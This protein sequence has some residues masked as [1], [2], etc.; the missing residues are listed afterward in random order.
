MSCSGGPT[1]PSRT[2]GREH[3]PSSGSTTRAP[4]VL[5]PA[6]IY[7]SISGFGTAE[8]A[9]L[10][11]YD[12]VVQAVSGLM[13]LTGSPDGPAFR[14]GI[15]VFDVMTG[16]HATIGI[17]ARSAAP[18]CHRRG[19]VGGVEPAVIGAVGPRE[20]D[21]RLHRLGDGAPPHGQRPPQRLPLRGDLGQ[22]P[23]HD[24]HRGQRPSVQGPVRG[25]RHRRAG[26]GRAVQTQ[27]RPHP[28]PRTRC[29]RAWRRQWP[30]GT[31]TTCSSP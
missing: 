7:A 20:P 27:R 14:A 21:R 23:R 6:L 5:N 16:L 17:L 2:S 29:T 30:G 10:P 28:Q 3:W 18:Q 15:S 22:G 26:R 31:R 1:S 13:S 11:G 12:L 25:A 9:R 24:H 8:G 4:E 19:P